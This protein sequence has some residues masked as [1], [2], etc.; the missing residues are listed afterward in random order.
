M[1]LELTIH[2]GWVQV[3]LFLDLCPLVRH[4]YKIASLLL[5]WWMCSRSCNKGKNKR[6]MLPPFPKFKLVPTGKEISGFRAVFA[7]DFWS[8]LRAPYFSVNCFPLVN[9]DKS[10][11]WLGGESG[12]YYPATFCLFK[13]CLLICSVDLQ[14]EL[15]G[16]NDFEGLS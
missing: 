1:W 14:N 16:L 9:D 7:N 2:F 3:W 11:K 5:W 15:S 4:T 8:I 13:D 10:T 12:V 6:N